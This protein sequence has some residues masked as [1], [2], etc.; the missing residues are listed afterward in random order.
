MK[1][2]NIDKKLKLVCRPEDLNEDI[3]QAKVLDIKLN[4]K[5]IYKKPNAFTRAFKYIAQKCIAF[6]LLY[7]Y[8]KI[9]LV[10]KVKGKKTQV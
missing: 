2:K 1:Q 6:P 3:Y 8:D 5:K 7:L 10:V 9:Y 4:Y